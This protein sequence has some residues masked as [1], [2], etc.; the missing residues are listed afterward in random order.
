MRLGEGGSSFISSS[1]RVEK[2][3]TDTMVSVLSFPLIPWYRSR[4]CLSI[5][6]VNRRMK[7]LQKEHDMQQLAQQKEA[8]KRYL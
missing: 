8:E 7:E 3:V 5:L 2:R 1:L 6:N 4:I